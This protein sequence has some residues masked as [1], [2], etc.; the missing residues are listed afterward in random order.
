MQKGFTKLFWGFLLILIEVH[1]LVI[2]ILPDPVGYFLI[3]QG[4]NHLED[5]FGEK[6]LSKPIAGSL[7]VISIPTIFIDQT[8]AI[9]TGF[10]MQLTGWSIYE[11]FLSLA[12]LILTFYVFKILI[13]VA[14]HIGDQELQ[15]TTDKIFRLYMII[16]VTITFVQPFFMNMYGDVLSVIIIAAAITSLILDI[17]FLV[18]LRKFRKSEIKK[19]DSLETKKDR[20]GNKG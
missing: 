10:A 5:M 14:R 15:A 4:L 2:D 20:Y 6:N 3:Y 7:V 9:Q 16:M 18:L 11:T 13:K 1:F 12:Q 8:K 19:D 17:T